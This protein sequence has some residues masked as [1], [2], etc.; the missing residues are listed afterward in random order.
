MSKNK[1]DEANKKVE[2]KLNRVDELTHQALPLK[3]TNSKQKNELAQ[4]QIAL[5][6]TE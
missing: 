1:I 6:K 2:L 3:E 4:M 5:A